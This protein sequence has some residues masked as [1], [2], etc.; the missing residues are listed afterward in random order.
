MD[1]NIKL[2]NAGVNF[3]VVIVCTSSK[4]LED[5]WQMRLE[6]GV[7]TFL[8][9]S[10]RIIAVNEDWKGG[11]GN[12]LGTLYAYQKA[13]KKGLELHG[14]DIDQELST[15][16]ISIGLFH[17][18]GK[19][20]RLAPL[21]GGE[22]NNKPGVKLPASVTLKTGVAPI[23]ILEAVIKQTGCYA[24][25]RTGRLS[26]FWGD[27]IFVPSESVTYTPKHHVDILCRMGP[28]VNE[29]EWKEKG[30]QN[31]GLIVQGMDGEAAQVE[32]VDHPTALKMLKSFGEI[33][34]VGA[35]LGSFSLS[36]E[37]LACLLVEF[38]HELSAKEGKMDS[39]PHFWM[40]MT[41][42]RQVYC[43][44]MSKKG[45]TSVSAGVH[46]DRISKMMT[47]F[48]SVDKHKTLGTFGAVNIGAVCSWWD[49]G[50]LKLYQQNAL[51]MLSDSEDGQRMRDFFG[52]GKPCCGIGAFL[53]KASRISDST[54]GG[55]DID[56]DSVVLTSTIGSGS[57]R[58]SIVNNVRCNDIQAEGCILVNVTAKKIVAKPGSIVYNVCDAESDCLVIEDK[59]VLVG[60][61]DDK[62]AQVNMRSNM[63]TDGGKTWDS[64]IPGNRFSFSQIY[65]RNST[66]DPI[67][68]EA[69]I[70]KKHADAWKEI[71]TMSFFSGLSTAAYLVPA[72]L[73]AAAAVVM[74]RRK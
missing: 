18:A 29:V 1:D 42:D 50:Q 38:E 61:V 2:M 39:D 20:T 56:K 19:G 43:D 30:L 66:A 17:S 11:A 16:K 73:V 22:N 7:G 26:V 5:Y 60:I 70:K 4:N 59:D 44:V 8:P 41:L 49:Y 48:R 47:A 69:I 24:A 3:D 31:Y 63:D 57:V 52:V 34:S 58:G 54:V 71:S 13:V 12:A 9:A 55:V 14:K 27:Q 21:P 51:L 10:T 25:S 28:M 64:K 67:A 62:G 40:P 45:M 65:E 74:M 35:S 53:Q 72:A 68:L 15:E 46:F 32:K 36:G 23:T 6:S 37:F 33:D